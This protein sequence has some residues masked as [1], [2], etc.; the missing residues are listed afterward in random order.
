M[1]R[2]PSCNPLFAACDAP[3]GCLAG[4]SRES[5]V[6]GG[7]SC[8]LLFAAGG[9]QVCSGGRLTCTL[10]SLASRSASPSFQSSSTAS[11]CTFSEA[12]LA[13]SSPTARD[14]CP[15]PSWSPWAP[16]PL[17]FLP[18]SSCSSSSSS[19]SWM[20]KMSCCLR[21][22]CSLTPVQPPLSKQHLVQVPQVGSA[23][24]GIDFT[25]QSHGCVICFA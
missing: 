20:R 17:I 23:R 18:C 11:T 21:C 15:S 2:C 25:K 7:T 6:E 5:A 22:P 14:G 10:L 4:T 1:D 13:A 8:N 16:C 3:R 9:G 12:S 24:H 19:S